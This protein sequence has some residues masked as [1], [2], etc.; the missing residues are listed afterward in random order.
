MKFRQ[1]AEGIVER[2]E[3]ERFL[4]LVERLPALRAEELA[5]LTLAVDPAQR[6][7]NTA[8]GIF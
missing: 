3:Q 4:D 2:A 8:K 5:G 7:D 1:L 6:H